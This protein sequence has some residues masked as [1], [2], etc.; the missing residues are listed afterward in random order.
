VGEVDAVE[1][2]TVGQRK[3]LGLPGGGDA[4]YA[5]DVDRAVGVV[6][7]G[8][9]EHLLDD[10]LVLDAITWTDGPAAGPVL[11]QT[12][13]HGVPRRGLLDGDELRWDRPERRVARGQSVVLY[14][15]DD[16]TVLGGGLAR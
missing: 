13:A 9:A 1:L 16:D 7:V 5:L 14:T 4:L 12:S 15:L 10:G 3:G 11:V 2:V 6:T 8:P